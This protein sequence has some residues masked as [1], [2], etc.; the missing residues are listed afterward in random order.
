ML[1]FRAAR[2]GL[3]PLPVCLLAARE[4]VP[5]SLQAEKRSEGG[6]RLS[7]SSDT[8][9]ARLSARRPAGD[10]GIARGCGRS[11][12]GDMGA[13][14]PALPAALSDDSSS[15]CDRC[16]L[17]P[18]QTPPLEPGESRTRLEQKYF[19]GLSAPQSPSPEGMEQS[20]LHSLSVKQTLKP[21]LPHPA[22]R[23]RRNS[24]LAQRRALL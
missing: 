2:A 14:V 16:W 10:A 13:D 11:L 18:L 24:L 9:P 12:H 8:K 21:L 17:L 15:Y 22:E 6:Q 19:L 1:G 20:S 4:E 7:H 3:T 23:K 5:L